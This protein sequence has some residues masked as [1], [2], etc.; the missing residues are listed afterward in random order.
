VLVALQACAAT[1]AAMFS[2]SSTAAVAAL[3]KRAGLACVATFERHYG[4]GRKAGAKAEVRH[5]LNLEVHVVG[6]LNEH[7]CL[8][9]RFFLGSNGWC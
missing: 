1:L 7:W 2:G 4:G 9:A 8:L 6:R 3:C 5:L